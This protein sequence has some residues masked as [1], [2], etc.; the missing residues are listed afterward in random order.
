MSD[1]CISCN[2]VV[3]GRPFEIV[4]SLFCFF[5]SIAV[6]VLVLSSSSADQRVAS[7]IPARSHEIGMTIV[8][9]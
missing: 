8:V 1:L 3:N 9:D 6:N 7:A 2:S 5:M 4:L